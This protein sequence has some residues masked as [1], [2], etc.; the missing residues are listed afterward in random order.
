MYRSAPARRGQRAH[1]DADDASAGPLS[2]YV[3]IPFCETKCPYCDFNT[4][5]GIEPLIPE[6]VSALVHELSLWG[7]MLGRPEVATVFF[8]GGTPSYLPA[9]H[10][11]SILQTVRDCFA[12]APDSEVTLESNPGDFGEAKLAAYLERGVNRLSIGV[13]SLDDSLLR[14]LGRRHSAEQ[15]V[16]AYAMALA[17]GFDNV[18]VDLM[19]GLPYQTEAA[20]R[21]TLRGVL[22]M[23]P[24]HV[25]A[26]CLTLEEGT[27]MHRW[28]D[29]GQVAE[30]DPDLAA[31]MYEHTERA[32]ESAGYRHYEISNWARD[33]YESRHN[34]TY[35]RNQPYL[36]VGP[37]A[38]SY[39]GSFRFHNLRSPREYVRSLQEAPAA[40]VSLAG[41]LSQQALRKV[42]VVEEVEPIDRPLEMAET[43]MMGLR[44]DVGVSIDEFAQRFDATPQRAYGDTIDELLSLG[45]LERAAGHLRLTPRGRILGN[46]VFARF[47]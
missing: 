3:H 12:L 20:W 14:M 18:S 32:M 1:R 46:E 28:V 24:P 23:E 25:S 29:S 27:P 13:Q 44:L 30:P 36:G 9:G 35:W 17:A 40:A 45:L 34:L 15:A 2:L 21:D 37:G 11:A 22:E 41:C 47:F 5:A 31:D 16:Q 8:G 19:Y 7:K 38:H 43:L 10:V 42:P 6:Y 26:Y 33:G 4:Y 39:L